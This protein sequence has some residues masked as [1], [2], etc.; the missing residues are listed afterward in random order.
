M[1]R[2]DYLQHMVR[3]WKAGT[4]TDDEFSFGVLQSL[5]TENVAGFMRGA[6]RAVRALLEQAA[7]GAPQSERD[8]CDMLIVRSQ[9]G[10]SSVSEGEQRQHEAEERCRYRTGVEA[11][12]DFIDG[13]KRSNYGK[14]RDIG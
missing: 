14:N 11:V 8:W 5:T 9:C 13:Q 2:Q 4:Y 1:H 7:A 3:N 10:A 6:P 12:R